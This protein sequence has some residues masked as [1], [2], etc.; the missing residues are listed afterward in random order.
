MRLER[1]SCFFKYFS[2]YG[3]LRLFSFW[4]VIIAVGLLSDKDIRENTFTVLGTIILIIGA[5]T[6]I[7]YITHRIY[8]IYKKYKRGELTR[9]I[10]K[11]KIKDLWLEK[12]RESKGNKIAIVFIILSFS[13]MAIMLIWSFTIK[14]FWTQ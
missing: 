2:G 9:Q 10:I 11:K 8:T 7:Y 4:I 12:W 14:D 1:K 6:F 5:I 3:W 13:F